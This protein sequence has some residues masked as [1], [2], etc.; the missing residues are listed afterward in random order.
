MKSESGADNDGTSKRKS[1]NDPSVSLEI[2][3]A[4]L[5]GRN[6]ISLPHTEK[7]HSKTTETVLL[8]QCGNEQEQ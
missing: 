1:S 8:R 3:G 4:D 2:A 6:L 5:R 7:W